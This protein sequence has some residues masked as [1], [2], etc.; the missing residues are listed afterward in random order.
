MFTLSVCIQAAN[1]RGIPPNRSHNEAITLFPSAPV[2]SHRS[3]SAVWQMGPSVDEWE[4]LLLQCEIQLFTT[5]LLPNTWNKEYTNIVCPFFFSEVD[6][7][8][9][10][11]CFTIK[12]LCSSC[13]LEMSQN[14]ELSCAFQRVISWK[15]W[16][17]QGLC[18]V[19][20]LEMYEKGTPEPL[21]DT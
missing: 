8:F 15:A 19:G 21:L 11:K 14:R 4:P 10:L 20:L 7:R 5:A 1:K 17:W 9:H 12:G 18:S 16:S 13:I 3:H 2:I 6:A